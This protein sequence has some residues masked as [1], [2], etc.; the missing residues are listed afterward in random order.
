MNSLLHKTLHAE[1]LLFFRCVAV[2]PSSGY[3]YIFGILF[4]DQVPSGSVAFN[5]EQR[6]WAGLSLNQDISVKPY[7]FDQNSE[8][9][10]AIVLETDFLKKST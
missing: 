8:C 4:D 7:K 10:A 1:N 2:I 3:E 6:K 5:S 9:L